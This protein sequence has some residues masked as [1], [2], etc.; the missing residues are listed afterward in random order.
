MKGKNNIN[1][2]GLIKSDKI[3]IVDNTLKFAWIIAVLII[4]NFAIVVSKI[5][6]FST[7]FDANLIFIILLSILF[8]VTVIYNIINWK[9]TNILY[10]EDRVIIYKSLISIDLAEFLIKNVTGIVIEQNIIG[11][12]F[13]VVRVKIYTNQ[14]SN[15]KEDLQI[16]VKSKKAHE[17]KE[18]ILKKGMLNEKETIKDVEDFDTF[19]LKIRPSNILLHSFLSISLGNIIIVANVALILFTMIYKG[20]ILNEVLYNFIGFAITILTIV[21][22]V[23]YSVLSSFIKYSNYKLKRL[24]NVTLLRYGVIITRNY[25]VLNSQI[26]GIIIKETLLSKIFK[27]N[28]VKIICSGSLNKKSE[29]DFLIPMVSKK[30]TVK[31]LNI[32]F[33]DIKIDKG[34]ISDDN[35]KYPSKF[36]FASYLFVFLFINLL[37]VPVIM[38]LMIPSYIVFLYLF[39]S[40]IFL[41]ML[42]SYTKT[43]INENGIVIKKGIFITSKTVIFYNKIKYIQ[44]VTTPINNLFNIY[45]VIIYVSS[46]EN[47]NK[48][49]TGYLSKTNLNK[50]KNNVLNYG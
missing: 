32:I 12:L 37:V 21:F 26:N 20:T 24:S 28:L 3:S 2:I 43:G 16:V 44:V 15:K 18:Y 40:V 33:K 31:V 39:L 9:I 49:I 19:N 30:E 14:I 35:T 8:S 13:D 34:I 45:I 1:E 23:L 6:E 11:K 4:T 42:Y 27:Y 10:N 36:S 48:T 17:L 47:G 50:V 38:Y 29:L 25:I 5:N 22:P 7:F 46:K 41:I